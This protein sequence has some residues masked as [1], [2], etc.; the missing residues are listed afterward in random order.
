MDKLQT[1]TLMEDLKLLHQFQMHKIKLLIDQKDV[2]ELT[3][4]SKLKSPVGKLL[5]PNERHLTNI[6]GLIFFNKIDN[7]YDNW[8]KKYLKIY[9]IFKDHLVEK[10]RK[11]GFFSKF[12]EVSKVSEM[13]IDEAKLYYSELISI[14]SE[15]ISTLDMCKRRVSALSETKFTEA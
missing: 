4:T 11:K 3:D 7:F 15:L 10:N 1:V 14:S 12:A 13:D 9:A 6:L 8:H 2:D 5:Y